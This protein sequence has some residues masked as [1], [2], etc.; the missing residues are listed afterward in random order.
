MKNF[1]NVI[2]I[3]CMIL[4]II[5]YVKIISDIHILKSNSQEVELLQS[6]INDLKNIKKT[7]SQNVIDD[8]DKEEE[9]LINEIPIGKVSKDKFKVCNEDEN[10]YYTKEDEFDEEELKI[11]GLDVKID[12][13][14]VYVTI[15]GDNETLQS[16]SENSNLKSVEDEEITGLSSEPSEIYY[17]LFGQDITDEVVLFLMED[18]TVEYI[19][20]A[21]M[22]KTQTYRSEGQIE[23]LSDVKKFDYLAVSDVEGGGYETTIA[24]DKNGYYYDLNELL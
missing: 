5:L 2:I 13:G 1:F 6:Q 4:L 10:I 19:K 23:E 20:V 15:D 12:S 14:K 21:D 18:G 11:E 22:L 7:E 16:I 24:I 3:V 17:G 8:E 9:S